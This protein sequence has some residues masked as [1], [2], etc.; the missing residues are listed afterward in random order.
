MIFLDTSVLVAIAQVDHVH[1]VPSRELWNGC[2]AKETAVSAHTLAEFY[3]SVT[4][5]P[6]GIRLSGRDAML[7]L[8]TFLRRIAPIALAA[9][10]YIETL[11][12]CAAAGLTG[13][14]IYDALHV[15]CARKVNAERIYT[16]NVR[17]FQRVAPDL[18]GKIVAPRGLSNLC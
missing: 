5:M 3:S 6:P 12:S 2:A 9:S 7:A 15:A 18:A 1:H 14:M 8:E 13:G 11:K 16:W 10:E 17:H 4:S